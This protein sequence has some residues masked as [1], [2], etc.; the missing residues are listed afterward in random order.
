MR[1]LH[2]RIMPRHPCGARRRSVMGY[3]PARSRARRAECRLAEGQGNVSATERSVLRRTR[4]R[5]SRASPRGRRRSGTS[6]AAGGD[7][8]PAALEIGHYSAML[9]RAS[10]RPVVLLLCGFLLFCA[11]GLVLTPSSERQEALERDGTAVTGVITS[12]KRGIRGL[13]TV[14]YE[15]SYAGRHEGRIMGSDFYE[16][17]E[18]VRVFV[19]PQRP[20][21]S[22]LAG[23]QPQSVWGMILTIAMLT[24]SVILAVGGLIQLWRRWRPRQDVG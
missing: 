2:E 8:H 9:A 4:C 22:T 23:E 17:G 12:V 14:T 1:R 7:R 6:A 24:G 13:T 3:W 21:R 20:N 15:Y 11:T 5:S 19:D 16:L 10:R 18:R